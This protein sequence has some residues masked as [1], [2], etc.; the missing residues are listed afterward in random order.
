MLKATGF[1]GNSVELV[2]A[3]LNKWLEKMYK[4]HPGRFIPRSTNMT[5]DSDGR[6]QVLVFYE[7]FAPEEMLEESSGEVFKDARSTITSS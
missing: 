7:V 5:S 4:K 2:A 6:I 1:H 3:E